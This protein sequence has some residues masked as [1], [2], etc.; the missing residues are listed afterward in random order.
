MLFQ[1]MV[2][3]STVKN[4]D[5]SMHNNVLQIVAL[6]FLIKKKTF[7]D[8]HPHILILNFYIQDSSLVMV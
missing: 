7:K 5:A 3:V 8:L 2:V 4:Q 6:E 1:C